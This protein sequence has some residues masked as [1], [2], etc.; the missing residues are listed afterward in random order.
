M[1]R[2]ASTTAVRVEH[3]LGPVEIHLRSHIQQQRQCK[4][5]DRKD[6]SRQFEITLSTGRR[7]VFMRIAFCGIIEGQISDIFDKFA[8]RTRNWLDIVE[9]GNRSVGRQVEIDVKRISY[10][11]LVVDS[12]RCV[13]FDGPIALRFRVDV[14]GLK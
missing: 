12:L 8:C 13:G 6:F 2:S 11:A 10:H 14:V 5:S 7:E 3:K 4:S 9:I 1:M